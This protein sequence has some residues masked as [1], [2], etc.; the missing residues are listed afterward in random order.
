M[1]TV[2]FRHRLGNNLFQ[3]AAAY[4]LAQRTGDRL[5]LPPSDF[6][7][8]FGL[9]HGPETPAPIAPVYRDPAFTYTPIPHKLGQDICLRG[10][11]QSEKY[12]ADFAEDLREL[13]GSYMHLAHG[14][15][16]HPGVCAVHVRRTDY[17]NNPHYVNLSAEYYRRLMEADPMEFLFFSDDI[18]FCKMKFGHMDCVSF[19]EERNPVKDLHKMAGCSKIIGS[20]STFAWWGAWLSGHDNCVFPQEWFAGP[21]LRHDTRDLIPDRWIRS[22]SGT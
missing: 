11:F 10:Y 6:A 13:L 4:A 18:E 7:R 21:S 22:R 5:V 3:F 9:H 12:F 15:E 20:N 2:H 1:I 8:L 14:I 16:S 19:S 17:V